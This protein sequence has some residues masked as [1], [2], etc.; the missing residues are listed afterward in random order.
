VSVKDPRSE[1]LELHQDWWCWDHPVSFAP[2]PA[3]VALL[4]YLSDTSARTAALRVQ[5][6]SHR[7]RATSQPVTVPVKAGDAVACDYRVLHGTH[8]NDVD[9]P[10]VCLILNFTPSWSSLPDEI[11]AHLIRHPALAS[12]GED[13]LLPAYDGKPRD[14]PLN[15]AAPAA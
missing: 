6:G 7:G 3:Q 11:R 5:P 4:A 2:E 9:V 14:L 13:D 10:R 15:R 12:A 1:E 8:R